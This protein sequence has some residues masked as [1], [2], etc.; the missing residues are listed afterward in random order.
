MKQWV[1]KKTTIIFILFIV[2][3]TVFAFT[4]MMVYATS[5]TGLD[6]IHTFYN[7]SFNY[8]SGSDTA[9]SNDGYF[10][11]KGSKYELNAD[12]TCAWIDDATTATEETVYF[13]V[14]KS[15]TLGSFTLNSVDLGE[16]RDGIFNN[17]YVVGF[18][19]GKEIFSTTQYSNDKNGTSIS[20]FPLNCDAAAGKIIDSFRIY[21]TKGAGSGFAHYDFSI[22]SF[23]ISN[24]STEP[25]PDTIAPAAVTNLI[26]SDTDTTSGVD[27]RDFTVS[28]D[29][30]TDDSTDV[31]NYNIYIYKDGEEPVDKAAMDLLSESS[32]VAVKTITKT[33]GDDGADANLGSGV[34]ADSKGQLLTAGDYRA[35]VTA[36]DAA[37]NYSYTKIGTKVAIAADVTTSLNITG[38]P[39]AENAG[40]TTV[41]ATLSGVLSQAVTV[42]LGFAGTAV[43]GT[44]YTATDNQIAILAGETTG[45]ITFTGVNDSVDENDETIIVDIASVSGAS[46]NGEQQV[47]ATIT[48]DDAEP[49]VS[50][51]AP[52]V[53]EGDTGTA[54]LVY[55]VTL[56]SA[57]GKTVTVDYATADGTA[58]TANSDYVA[59]GNTT[60]TFAPGETS[61]TITVSVNGDNTHEPDETVL[62]NLSTPVNASIIDTLGTGT[63]NNDDSPSIS[64]NDVSIAEENAGTTNL[65]F[66]VSLSK[67]SA[68]T[69]TV[70]YVT[71]QNTAI[72]E[73][74]YITKNGTVTFTAG[75]T[76]QT[77]TIVLIGDTINEEDEEFYVDLSNASNGITI[78]KA[79]GVG[80]ITNDDV[81]PTLSIADVTVTEGNL[82]ATNAEFTVTLSAA[83]GKTVAV[84]Y[85]TADGTATVGNDYLASSGSLSFPPGETSKTI[86]VQVSGDILDEIDKGF[87]VNLS[88][89]SNAS[90]S[91][92]KGIAI[93]TDDDAPPAV[94]INA[95]SVIEGD[96]GTANLVYTVTLSSVSGKTVTVDYT[97]ANGTAT[98]ANSDYV[99]IGNTT[100]TFAPGETSKTI[101]V[102]V[103]GDNTQ[104][105]DETVIINLSNPGN[106][107]IIDTQGTGTITNNDKP[108][109]KVFGNTAEIT[110][111]DTTPSTTDCTDFGS[112]EVAGGTVTRIFTISNIGN[113]ALVLSGTS[114]YV[115]MSGTNKSDFSVVTSPA[116][117]ITNGGTTTFS[118][119]FDPSSS[120]TRNAKITITNN[121][122]NNNPFVFDI[123]G[124]GTVPSSNNNTPS[125]PT[126]KDDKADIIFGGNAKKVVATAKVE[127]KDNVK[128]TTITLDDSEV[129][130]DLDKMDK[131]NQDKTKVNKVI[132]PVNN[133]SNIVIGELN[134]QTIKAMEDKKVAL[135]IKT[136]RVSYTIPATDINIDEVSD[137]LG[138]QIKL[139]DIKVS[140]KISDS[141]KETVSIVQNTADKNSYQLVVK[142]V[143]FEITC[144]N[145]I[146]EI[147]VSKFNNYV[148]RTVAIPDGIDPKK[149]TTGVVLNSDGTFSHVPT[150]IIVVGG[151][152][153]AKINSLTNSTYT[154][155]WNPVTFKDVENHWSKDYVNVVGS[156]LIDSGV[157]NGNF[158]PNKAITRAEFASMMVK[159]LGLK[160]TNFP[161]KFSDVKKSD[162][163][164]S[165]IYTAYEYGILEGYTNGKFGPQDLITR[166]QAMTMLSKAMKTTGMNGDVSKADINQL[167]LFKDSDDISSYAKQAVSICTKYGIFSG[168]TKGKLT[169]KDSFTRAESATV[170]IKL[171]QKSKLI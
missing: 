132:I 152:Y 74:D 98:T 12:N 129:Q 148:E 105:S 156:R 40:T 130:E 145:G 1:L 157:G 82:G 122:N 27:G 131:E 44:D 41:T 6:G 36:Q 135:E 89:A 33:A 8:I 75:Q 100:L 146:S 94:S 77:T 30:S 72:A 109:I 55:T 64:I 62:I 127:E 80:T 66:T 134:G 46:E 70:D 95:P 160:G 43:S 144:R 137:R 17:V 9:T 31:L 58:T 128:A 39:L 20:H 87:E 113:D 115:T 164:Y 143:D 51:N 34:T 4:P 111:G 116:I 147:T 68:G 161:N 56:S 7:T 50:I 47:T 18:A 69:V 32:K 57:S 170:I 99:A 121:D 155:I 126:P 120:G 63:I 138:K 104:E 149:I 45:S 133:N 153:Y 48:D 107:S 86:T 97:T 13:D 151:K 165:Y 14:T 22:Y 24:A 101:T 23:T 169:P 79:Q 102:S 42:N 61:K 28:F 65:S 59:I 71:A 81:A 108:N 168:D 15:S 35:I 84:N 162:P 158:A 49:T 112:T 26:L 106:A 25:A 11:L 154:V 16:Y 38:S 92:S 76:T 29:D 103:N 83:S 5:L 19:N 85:V 171:L 117:T 119:K 142:P 136:E 140:V 139:K 166:E 53:I 52:S 123:K 90:I 91:D 114:P 163:C 78:T 2:C 159:A 118:I 10:L 124:E 21:Y 3:S 96:T 141:S 110:N 93:I 88:S 167:K 54:N 150:A 125:V 37:G 60:L 67:P 73:T